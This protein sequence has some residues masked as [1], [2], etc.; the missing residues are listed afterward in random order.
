M[1]G[2]TFLTVA[3]IAGTAI[4]TVSD[5]SP[6]T[7]TIQGKQL[8]GLLHISDLKI[9]ASAS[10]ASLISTDKV[11]IEKIADSAG[12]GSIASTIEIGTARSVDI[13]GS[14]DHVWLVQAANDRLCMFTPANGGFNMGCGDADTINTTGMAGISSGREGNSL[15]AVEIA[16]NGAPEMKIDSADGTT[17]TVPFVD[18]VAVTHV[19]PNDVIFNGVA[20]INVGRLPTTGK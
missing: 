20:T 19:K 18:N 2:A 15:L 11:A 13:P 3:A 14:P 4:A 16:P 5:S 6:A 12:T 8:G 7:S 10:E 9:F 1:V 17:R